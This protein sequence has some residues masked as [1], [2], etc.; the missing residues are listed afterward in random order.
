MNRKIATALGTA[1]IAASLSVSTL[2]SPAMAGGLIAFYLSP[3]TAQDAQ[4]MDFGLRGYSLYNG[5][6]NGANIRQFGRNNSAGIGQN[7]NGNL[8][9]VR[10]EGRDHS[11]T[12]QQNGNGNSYG[13][14]QFGSNTDTEV[15][16]SGNGQSGAALLFGW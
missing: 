11:A 4:A 1:A 9:I 3:R 2:A 10:Q 13:I 14:F 7:G 15:V 16:Q 5:L 12:L 8:G 6:R